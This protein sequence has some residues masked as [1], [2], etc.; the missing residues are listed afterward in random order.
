[1]LINQVAYVLN[2]GALSTILHNRFKYND[3][4]RATGFSEVQNLREKDG[5]E[6]E[7]FVSDRYREQRKETKVAVVKKN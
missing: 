1:M 6:Y 2:L 4:S 5:K 7:N 3:S